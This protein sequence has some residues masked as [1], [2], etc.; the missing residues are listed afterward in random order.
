MRLTFGF[1]WFH[2]ELIPP[3]FYKV[4]PQ[5]VDLEYLNETEI[6]ITEIWPDGTE[7]KAVFEPEDT[8]RGKMQRH[9][10]ASQS[11]KFE[12]ILA[13]L[14]FFISFFS[15]DWNR[16]SWFAFNFSLGTNFVLL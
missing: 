15:A 10:F 8:R 4:T 14:A 1:P 12:L 16:F 7:K 9:L 13:S 3:S 6:E 2:Q 5:V 11:F